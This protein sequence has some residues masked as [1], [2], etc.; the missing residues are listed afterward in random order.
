MASTVTSPAP[1]DAPRTQ[2][3]ASPTSRSAGPQLARIA[4]MTAL[5][6]VLGV[7]PGKYKTFGELNKHVLKPAVDEIN[8]LA[9]FNISVLPAKQGKR[10]AV[11]NGG[12]GRGDQKVDT[13][14]RTQVGPAFDAVLDELEL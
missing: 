8:A 9:S 11:I 5:I 2:R 13:L 12:P 3:P 6:A 10:V 1:T 7:M 14:W 4:V